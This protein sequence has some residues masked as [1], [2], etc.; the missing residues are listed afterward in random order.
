VIS[1]FVRN[2]DIHA[3][4]PVEIWLRQEPTGVVEIGVD[5]AGP[6]V[7]LELRERI[8]ERFSRGDEARQRPGSGLGLAIAAEHARK[9]GGSVR[10][11]DSP[12]GGASFILAIPIDGPQGDS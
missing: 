1:N 7:P 6:G 9:L 10:V 11:S 3:S 8:F 2:T 12:L 5:D 4:G